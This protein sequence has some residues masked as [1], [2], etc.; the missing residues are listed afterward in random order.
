VKSTS[1]VVRT[2]TNWIAAFIFLYGLYIVAYGHLTPG[3]GFPGGVILS[4]AFVLLVLARGKDGAE[5]IFPYRVAKSLDSAGALVFLGLALL[6]LMSIW[7]TFFVNF[8]QKA[9][10]GEP[11][12]L[13]NA[14]IIP[15]CNIA[16]AT[17]VCASLFLVM[18]VFSVL[19]VVAGGADSEFISEEE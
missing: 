7:G 2:V 14:G 3:G 12:R 13:F 5:R 19:R 1:V 15:L 4:C 11:G 6:G 10:P 18:V 9:T 17:K 16:I 8:V